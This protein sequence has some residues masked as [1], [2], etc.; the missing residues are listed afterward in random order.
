MLLLVEIVVIVEVFEVL[1][2][3]LLRPYISIDY[4]YV[5]DIYNYELVEMLHIATLK[6]S[7][8]F[9]CTM[10]IVQEYTDELLSLVSLSLVC[11][12]VEGQGV[13]PFP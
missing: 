4:R 2:L 12:A 10:Q 1:L 9:V 6:V 11:K 5:Q 13:Q 7:V 3:L 8:L